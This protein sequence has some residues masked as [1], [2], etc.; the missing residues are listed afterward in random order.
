MLTNFCIKGE[1]I[2]CYW[3]L[4]N[5]KYI[6]FLTNFNYILLFYMINQK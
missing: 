6:K 2:D 5:F 4:N 1:K 3:K